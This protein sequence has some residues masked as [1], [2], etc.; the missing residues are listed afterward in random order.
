M[1]REPAGEVVEGPRNRAG[2]RARI[3]FKREIRW[4]YAG[5]ATATR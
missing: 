4:I 5:H 2:H 1:K 3:A